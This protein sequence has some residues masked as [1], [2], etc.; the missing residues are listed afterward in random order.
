MKLHFSNRSDVNSDICNQCTL[1]NSARQT[2]RGTRH[3][4]VM[5]HIFRRMSLT[6][7]NHIFKLLTPIPFRIRLTQSRPTFNERKVHSMAATNTNIGLLFRIG[8]RDRSFLSAHT[9]RVSDRPTTEV[10][11]SITKSN[12]VPWILMAEDMQP[13]AAQ[14]PTQTANSQM[15]TTQHCQRH[16]S[17]HWP[18]GQNTGKTENM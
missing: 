1:L 7:T 2:I 8:I 6:L 14:H 9:V 18:N 10:Q 17:H 4:Q 11:F 16:R 15:H 12:R 13:Y 3:I 5:T